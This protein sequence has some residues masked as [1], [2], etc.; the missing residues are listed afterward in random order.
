MILIRMLKVIFRILST[1]RIHVPRT[2]RFKKMNIWPITCLRK[3]LKFQFH[4]ITKKNSLIL[5]LHESL[6]VEGD[7]GHGLE[8]SHD[9]DGVA[10]A[11]KRRLMQMKDGQ[12]ESEENFRSFQQKAIPN[13]EQRLRE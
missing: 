4:P 2:V 3:K 10:F 7:L 13:T 9:G 11:E 8:V 5:H 6:D 1:T 12:R